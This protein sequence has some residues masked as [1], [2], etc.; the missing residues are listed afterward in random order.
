MSIEIFGKLPF[1]VVVNHIL[2][3][4]YRTKP[5]RHLADIR[6]FYSDL[7]FIENYYY[8]DLNEYIL[9]RDIV[10]FYNN[11]NSLDSGIDHKFTLLLNRSIVFQKISLEEKYVFIREHYND[12]ILINIDNKIRFL[13]G[14][15]KPKERTAFINFYIIRQLEKIELE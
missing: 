2:P 12:N 14:L 9:L 5:P 8:I 3:F 15:M 11:N 6:S 7:K 4:T 13:W 10:Y 1:D